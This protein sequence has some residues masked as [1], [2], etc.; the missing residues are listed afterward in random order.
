[1]TLG[2]SI[3]TELTGSRSRPSS[4]S[5]PS[6]AM[7]LPRNRP[8]SRAPKADHPFLLR[9]RPRRRLPCRLSH[10]AW[11]QESQARSSITFERPQRGP[12][13]PR[14]PGRIPNLRILSRIRNH[15]AILTRRALFCL[16]LPHRS[17]QATPIPKTREHHRGSTNKDPSRGATV[18]HPRCRRRKGTPTPI[19]NTA[20]RFPR[21]PKDI[22]TA[23]LPNNG[24]RLQPR[25]DLPT[26]LINPHTHPTTREI[27]QPSPIR[28]P[29]QP[30]NPIRSGATLPPGTDN[31]TPPTNNTPPPN[32]HRNPNPRP[33]PLPTSSTKT[34]PSPS[35]PPRPPPSRPRPSPPTPKRTSSS[36]SSPTPSTTSASV[37]APKTKPPS[38]ASSPSAP[39]CAPPPP[40]CRPSRRS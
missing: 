21:K 20:G 19:S 5:S 7:C 25:L 9:S 24:H 2:Y 31:N 8:S 33:L 14:S 3:W 26:N 32:P 15:R 27:R 28:N 23:A 12:P 36:T 10:P 40:P 22:P 6:C 16:H 11:H 1:M 13:S 18:S 37:R 39:P 38:R 30:A 17:P 34:S 29:T 4:T 35:P